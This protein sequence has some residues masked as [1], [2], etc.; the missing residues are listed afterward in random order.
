M[1]FHFL[2]VFVAAKYPEAVLDKG[3]RS[4]R[5]VASSVCA[6]AKR[7]VHGYV[8]TLHTVGRVT[9]TEM[10]LLCPLED[11]SFLMMKQMIQGG[12]SHTS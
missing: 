9:C 12:I 5:H 2:C 6:A 4:V 1:L 11:E 10:T 8:N 7:H 3:I